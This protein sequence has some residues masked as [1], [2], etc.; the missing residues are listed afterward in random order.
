MMTGRKS[1]RRSARRARTI[2][3]SNTSSGM[4]AS[5]RDS[6]PASKDH[7]PA[8]EVLTCRAAL[9]LR[10]RRPLETEPLGVEPFTRGKSPHAEPGRKTDP[11]AC[12][13][14]AAIL[15]QSRRGGLS[16]EA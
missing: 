8:A 6:G 5:Y 14:P 7:R 1:K 11:A 12:F 9:P 13:Y 16:R 15:E 3:T 4:D 2:A 10:F